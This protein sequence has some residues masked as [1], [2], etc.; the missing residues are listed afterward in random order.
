MSHVFSP[1]LFS[2][3]SL[4]PQMEVSGM[5]CVLFLQI[6]FHTESEVGRGV[7]FG[8]GEQIS[9]ELNIIYKN[10][11]PSALPSC[12]Q[13]ALFYGH[14]KTYKKTMI[15][16]M[17]IS[18]NFPFILFNCDTLQSCFKQCLGLSLLISDVWLALMSA[19]AW[20]MMAASCC[21]R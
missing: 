18:S 1:S 13:T 12:C 9:P 5:W 15:H 3:L 7:G 8:G 6:T 21:M 4:P 20:S 10:I 17:C 16:Q 19:Y 14:F 2:A 11:V